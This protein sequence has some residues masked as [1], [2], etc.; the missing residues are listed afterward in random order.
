MNKRPKEID[1]AILIDAEGRPLV[2]F[3][4]YA[5]ALEKYCDELE[6]E[7]KILENWDI[8]SFRYYQGMREALWMAINDAMNDIS[9]WG[10]YADTRNKRAEYDRCIRQNQSYADGVMEFYENM[11]V[12]KAW[13]SEKNITKIFEEL[14]KITRGGK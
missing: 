7:H 8:A 10:R 12:K 13:A 1:F 3:K 5:E 11:G 4:G 6:A 9:E 14:K 2:N